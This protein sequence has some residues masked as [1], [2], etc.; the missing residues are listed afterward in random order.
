MWRIPLFDLQLDEED[1]AS[2]AKTMRGGWL[3]LGERNAEFE[4]R[5]AEYVGARH[6]ISVSSGTAALHLATLALGIER[7]DEVICPTLTFVAG[8]NSIAYT[9]AKP[10][11]ADVQGP[12]DLTLS[13]KSVESLITP[14]T[15]AIQ[16]M[17]Y[18]GFP[19]D[20][21]AVVAV[22]RRYGLAVI[23]DCAHALGSRLGGTHCGRFG[24]TGCFSFFPNKNM[25]TAEGGMVITERDDVAEAVRLLRAHGMTR[26]SY[27]QYRGQAQGYDVVGLGYNY[28]LDEMRASLGVN[29]LRRLDIHNGIRCERVEHY[30]TRLNDCPDVEI[31]FLEGQGQ[32]SHHLFVIAVPARKRTGLIEHL[33]EK[34][35]Q[36][37]IHYPLAHRFEYYRDRGWG[38]DEELPQSV[39]MA[40]RVVSLPL[41][42]NMDESMVDEVC[43]A[44]I[45]YFDG[46][47]E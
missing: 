10:V 31:P 43:D 27:D 12:D 26:L 28:R 37:A 33:N 6:A 35:I 14:R 29:Q 20:M 45:D 9:G 25:T 21:D 40:D 46:E 7:D 38:N 36:T 3:T 44:V 22:A 5:F 23:E 17:H 24:D 2:V 15:R 18:A 32:S 19:C 41:Y 42:P 16:I 30:R 1:I 11:F 39:G 8:P 13:V 4:R 34:G 47:G